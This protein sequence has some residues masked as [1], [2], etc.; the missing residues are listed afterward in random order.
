M[1]SANQ[2]CGR[3]SQIRAKS[4]FSRK[5]I[6]QCSLNILIRKRFRREKHLHNLTRC[7]LFI[8]SSLR[9]K[10]DIIKNKF[11]QSCSDDDNPL[12]NELA[13]EI[14]FQ[15]TA[16]VCWLSLG[17]PLLPCTGVGRESE[18]IFS[19]SSRVASLCHELTYF[20]L[21]ACDQSAERRF[22]FHFLSIFTISGKIFEHSVAARTETEAYPIRKFFFLSSLSAFIFI[23]VWR[24]LPSESF[25]CRGSRETT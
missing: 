24:R 20:L 7:E 13:I 19:S 25:C 18:T 10:R 4:C 9:L 23:S 16:V 22:F 17:F 21:S 5:V 8:I 11:L 1:G 12:K 2:T 14:L 3:S 6:T 15:S